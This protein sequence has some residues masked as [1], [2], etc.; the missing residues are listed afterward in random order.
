ML[1]RCLDC[2]LVEENMLNC[3]NCGNI[4]VAD[5]EIVKACP[6]CDSGKPRF[7][8]QD[9]RGISCGYVCEDCV[10]EVKAKYRPEIFDDPCYYSDE[11]ID[12]D[13]W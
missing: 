10:D 11:P 2:G 6:R 5:N 13:G 4:T 8:L 1:Y 3:P 7:E 9:A 12:D